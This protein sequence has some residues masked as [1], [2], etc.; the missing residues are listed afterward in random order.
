[1]K[2]SL[3]KN[4]IVYSFIAIFLSLK[5]VGFHVFAHDDSD[6]VE[7]CEVCELVTANNLTP[8]IDNTTQDYLGDANEFC[9]QSEKITNYNFVYSTVV[10]ITCLFSRPPPF[11]I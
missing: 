7:H 1:M 6:A 9:F 3:L 2:A 8:I 5:V 4:Y 11:T 10:D